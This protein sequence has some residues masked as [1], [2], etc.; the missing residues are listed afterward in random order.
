M[1]VKKRHHV[2]PRFYL[3][4]FANDAE[5]ITTVH[6]AED[7]RRYTTSIANVGVEG[8]F[9]NL[10]TEEGWVT[11]VEDTLSRLEGIAAHDLPRLAAGRSSTLAAFRTRLSIFMAVQ[12]VRGRSPR[13]AMIDFY[14]DVYLKVAQLSTPEIIKAEAKRRGEAMTIEE[15]R[16]VWEFAQDP[17]LNVD[18][19]KVGPKG[20]P[21]DSLVNAA[22]VFEHGEKLIPFFFKRGWTVFEFDAP[23]LLTSDE[24]VA[25]GIESEFPNSPA[26]LA[27]ADTIVFPLDPCHA[28]MMSRP[29]HNPIPHRWAKGNRELARAINQVSAARTPFFRAVA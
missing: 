3:K 25:Q 27:N 26:G 8:H 28:L 13:E 29:D 17:T 10:P 12:F 23:V 18:F 22:D 24:P 1:G 7:F 4:R 14:K 16:E 15:A 9:Y 21:A 2:V 20:L 19:Q 11:T 6:P 5:E